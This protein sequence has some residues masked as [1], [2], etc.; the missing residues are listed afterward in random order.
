[1]IYLITFCIVA[2]IVFA[3]WG[4]AEFFLTRP[5]FLQVDQV[6]IEP[7]LTPGEL[8]RFEFEVTSDNPDDELLKACGLSSVSVGIGSM[9]GGLMEEKKDS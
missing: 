7:V 5:I 3:T 2:C 9:I 1:M 4:L 8:P 6:E